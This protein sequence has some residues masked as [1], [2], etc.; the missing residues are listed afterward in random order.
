M[1]DATTP[2]A[3]PFA[4][5]VVERGRSWCAGHNDL[6]SGTGVWRIG[7]YV[8]LSGFR[9]SVWLV[10]TGEPEPLR[11]AVD[12]LA[13]R[14]EPF[15]LIAPTRSAFTHVCSDLLKRAKS[16]FLPLAELMGQGD[17]DRL[18]LLDGHTA[19]GVLAEFRAVHVPQPKDEDGMVVFPTPAG[20]RWENVS[21]RFIDR[22]TVSVQVR[23][24]SGVFHYA[25]M[26]M[27]S[28]KNANPTVHWLLL[29]AFAEGH[30]LLDW[31]N[32]KASL[33][34]QKR[35]ENLA[36]DLQRFFRIDGDPFVIEGDGWRACFAVEA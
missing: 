32:R 16:C 33:K 2:P 30:G 27:A 25:Q 23:E 6:P 11:C 15:V 13:A 3:K 29:E 4:R 28:A 10:L 35:K 9:F 5:L 14:G 22:H 1:A 20:A 8:P 18:A 21:I 17:D 7:D 34:N 12:G 26:G 31:R 36:A 19:G 24:V